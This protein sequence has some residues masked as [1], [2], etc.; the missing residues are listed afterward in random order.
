MAFI[1]KTLSLVLAMI[2]SVYSGLY[3]KISGPAPAEVPASMQRDGTPKKYFTLSFDDGVTQDLKII[4]ICKKYNFKAIT[5]NINT[6]L[7]GANWDWVGK[8][9][10][11]P[12][13][14]HIRFTK[15]QI[16][17]GIY[18]GFDVEVHTMTHPSMKN[19][20]NDPLNI[21][22]EVE[23]DSINIS[24]WTGVRPVGM[25]WPGGDT[26]YTEETIRGVLKYTSIRFG[27][28]VTPTHSFDLPEYFLKWKPTCS[29]IDPELMNL[30]DRFLSA[31][32]SE[33][34]LFYVWGHG[35]ELDQNNGYETLETL[36]RMMSEN[37]EI[38]LVSNSQ[39]YQLFKDQIPAYAEN[40]E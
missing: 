20:D 21:W 28:A 19:S 40:A 29:I 15:G 7:C 3:Y 37:A 23:K 6:G 25:A 36:I 1:G 38:V 32:C 5:F 16:K 27:R 35:Y 31:E 22:K 11:N 2:M 18:D 13:I 12:D 39:F 26:E 33:D 34:M 14:T 17:S 30:A 10:G 9:I 8:A 24:K 4:E